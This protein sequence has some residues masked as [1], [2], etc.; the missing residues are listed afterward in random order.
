MHFITPFRRTM[1]DLAALVPA[2][3]THLPWQHEQFVRVQLRA[4]D[5]R[6]DATAPPAGQPALV[7]CWERDAEPTVDVCGE[8]FPAGRLRLRWRLANA[9]TTGDG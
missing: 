3:P 8:I 2:L 6:A 9:E 1:L 4:A 7:A 5:P